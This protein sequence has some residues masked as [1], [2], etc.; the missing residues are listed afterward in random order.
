M[1]YFHWDDEAFWKLGDAVDQYRK[2]MIERAPGPQRGM[3]ESCFN[4]GDP[5]DPITPHISIL[6]WQPGNKIFRHTHPAHR[7]ELLISGELETP[8]GKLTAG[9]VMFT[10]PNEAYGPLVAGPDGALT[11]EVIGRLGDIYMDFAHENTD[12]ELRE[13]IQDLL[14]KQDELDPEVRAAVLE[15]AAK[16]N[17]LPA[18]AT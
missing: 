15:T 2:V 10:G 4:L 11:V 1:A 9:T 14:D 8:N 16:G 5:D 12:P 3:R 18:D 17:L 7:F 6:K 13:W